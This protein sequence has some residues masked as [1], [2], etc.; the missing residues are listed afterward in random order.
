[1]DERLA[2]HY[3][4]PNVLGSRFRRV[5]VTDPNRFGLLGQ[6]SILTL[7]STAIRTSPVQRG[8]YVMEVL[9]GTPPPPPPPNVPALPENA[10]L[11]TGHVAKP[12]SVRERME[13]ASREPGVRRLPQ[14]DGPDRLRAGEF[15]R[16][17]S[18]AHQRQRLRAS[19]PRARCSTAPKLDGPVSLRQAMLNHSDAFLGT[20]TENLLAYGLGRVLEY[21]RHA[22]GARHRARGGRERQPFFVVRSGDREE[23]AVPD[24][25][26]GRSRAR[27]RY[28]TRWRR[29][30]Q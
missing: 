17:G 12:L 18:V 11:R 1:M 15:R 22:D 4:I 29:I 10:E 24:A 14:D 30:G 9:L 13:A 20:F 21:Q 8:K 28:A 5:P 6:G 2:K 25:E 7:T 23:R 19:I 26:G 27:G 16:G 3:G